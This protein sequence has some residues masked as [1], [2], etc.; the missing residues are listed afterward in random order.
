MAENA[1][2]NYD[3]IIV[4]AG[5][6]GCVLANRL[7]EDPDLSVL[8]LEAGIDRSED[9]QVYALG[10]SGTVLN[11]PDFDWQYASQPEPGLNDRI[12]KHPRGRVVGGTSAI[13]SFALIYPS[14]TEI[15]AWAETGEEGWNWQTLAPYFRKF[16]TIVP[17]T[18]D[19]KKELNTAHSD[20]NIRESNGPIQASSPLRATALQ[21]AWVDTFRT[22]GMHNRS[23]PLDGHAIGGHTSTC[24]I[25]GDVHER[26]HAGIAYLKP[27]LARSNL[28][29]VT[30]ALVHKLVIEQ[31][32]SA[33][34]ARGVIYS[35]DGKLCEV[36]AKKEVILTA[37]TFNSPQ[38]MELSG[39]GN[40]EVLKQHGIE[41]V[42]AN[43]AVGESLQ[44]H[45][46][47]G[48][49]FE[50]TDNVPRGMPMAL[51]EARKLYEKDRSGPWAELGAF[52]FSYTPLL[53][54]LD[55]HEM[56][57]LKKLL[58]KDLED[59]EGFSPFTHNRH[60]FIRKAIKSPDAATAVSFL[61]RRPVPGAPEGNYLTL[62]AMLSHPFSTGS[63]HIA[64][65]DPRAKPKIEFNYYSHPF[66]LEIHARQ[67]QV[68]KKLAQTEPL[69][70][71]IKP[72]GM[73]I[74]IEQP[75]DSVESAKELCRA[76]ASTNYHPCGTCALGEVVDGRLKVKGVANLRVVDA[77]VMPI[78]PRGN[79]ITTVYAIA[80]RAA[81]M[82]SEDLHISRQT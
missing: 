27:A 54:F 55:S 18:E 63:S 53:P 72:G 51:E 61:S 48:I 49:S 70:S 47:P 42:C 58:D 16:Q 68:L 64:S 31:Q 78:I 9:P 82:I 65:N 60:N 71:Y 8:L 25:T 45:I 33:Q 79:I 57:E 52:S 41:V 40:P 30:D 56:E 23:D 59:D 34:L 32:D 24:H 50:V 37:G 44:D 5:T 11:N 10:L 14:A 12:I 39:I 43:P 21:K 73:Q 15:D 66:D 7:S 13:N 75:A 80:E 4:G 19:V 46:R 69:A 17:P 67:I 81:D 6:A 38:I 28:N 74:P 62:H 76:H 35:K 2:Y 36:R 3:L 20:A 22:L 29:L 77:S 1:H 26:S